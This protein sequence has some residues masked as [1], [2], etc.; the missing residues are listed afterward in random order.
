[1]F[2]KNLEFLT[3]VAARTGT[4]RHVISHSGQPLNRPN[5]GQPTTNVCDVE[6]L[7]QM[8]QSLDPFAA[9]WLDKGR[10]YQPGRCAACC[11]CRVCARLLPFLGITDIK[12]CVDPCLHLRRGKGLP[13]LGITGIK[14]C[15]DPCLHLRRG[16]GFPADGARGIGEPEI[17]RLEDL[18]CV[19]SAPSADSS[20]R[21][22]YTSSLQVLQTYLVEFER[23]VVEQLR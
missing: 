19:Q 13:F 6:M 11:G 4:V 15:V 14:A 18:I 8:P 7:P 22:R 2:S 9:D 1:M 3:A 23:R 16:K 10:R 20:D 5:L 21:Q 12:A 17:D